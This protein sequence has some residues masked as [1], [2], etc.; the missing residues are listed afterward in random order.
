MQVSGKIMLSVCTVFL[1][2]LSTVSLF[3]IP[4]IFAA[5]EMSTSDTSSI[6]DNQVTTNGI[7]EMSVDP[8][9]GNSG[10]TFHFSYRFGNNGDYPFS[11]VIISDDNFD[12]EN[13]TP[14]TYSSG[15]TNE[16]GMVDKGETV[17]Y[18]RICSINDETIVSGHVVAQFCTDFD[19]PCT[20]KTISGDPT[21][22]RDDATICESEFAK[23]VTIS[24]V[25]QCHCTKSTISLDTGVLKGKII[26]PITVHVGQRSNTGKIPI[27]ITAKYFVTIQ[28]LGGD[29]PSCMEHW[30]LDKE[31]NSWY[32]DFDVSNGVETGVVGNPISRGFTNGED[33][34]MILECTGNDCSKTFEKHFTTTYVVE[35]PANSANIKGEVYLKVTPESLCDESNGIVSKIV[36][37][38]AI[39][40]L[41]YN[42]TQSDLDGDGLNGNQER[43]IASSD[44]SYNQNDIMAQTGL[45]DD[46]DSD[47][48]K[49]S[50]D[51]EP[52]GF[53]S[54]AIILHKSP[55]TIGSQ[56]EKSN[57]GLTTNST[58]TKLA[59][60]DQE[61][62]LEYFE[63]AVLPTYTTP[64]NQNNVTEINP[65]D[66]TSD[67]TY[68]DDLVDYE[69]AVTLPSDNPNQINADSTLTSDIS[70]AGSTLLPVND[71]F[72]NLAAFSG[73]GVST[74][75]PPTLGV[76]QNHKRI[77]DDGFSFN[78][79]AINVE[80]Y[81]TAY[82]LVTTP[83]GQNNTIK[84]KIYEEKGTDNIAHAGVSYGLG[85]GETFS[86]GQ[87]T[88]EYDK[89]FDGIE[90]VTTFD[91]KHV[92]GAVNVTTSQVK[93]SNASQSKCLEVTFHHT[94]RAPLEYN[95]VAT[96][97]WDFERDAWQNYFNH[98]IVIVGD[99][100]NPPEEYWGIYHGQI[101]HLTE[102]G[103]NIAKD[104][105]GNSWSFDRI[106]SRD[107]IK[108]VNVGMD[109]LNPEKLEALKK[110]GFQYSDG[111]KIFGYER[112][113][114]HF[115]QVVDQQQKIAQ[116][117]MK[118]LCP[119]CEVEHFEEIG[120]IFF[121]D[122]P[123]RIDKTKDPKII[124]QMNLEDQ[125]ARELLKEFFK[126]IYPD[127]FYK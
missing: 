108:P 4:N 63:R 22:I 77:V 69:S 114:P 124:N 50:D 116:D 5:N 105:K 82:P 46:F 7:F 43:S 18:Q 56:V 54:R 76:D 98:G 21:C 95:M 1:M 37:D 36:I 74:N 31:N 113:D 81:Y 120:D 87:A 25:K 51:S 6:S 118:N 90:S 60:G 100:I 10:D 85:K 117:T 92:L 99:S 30:N 104:D 65:S 47:G 122:I 38:S 57:D 70:T 112:I 61:T 127:I 102:T 126:K 29:L 83:V 17:L 111:M 12:S 89:T 107:Y 67:A 109:I 125:K 123:T 55:E 39:R 48:I 72:N 35:V 2:L 58:A 78:D 19:G 93:C 14:I 11:N 103:K 20:I 80:E 79:N 64:E 115:K 62:D 40:N 53:N 84:L 34:S 28:C 121:Y 52:A 91:P 110:R 33:G 27:T 96:N 13:C 106:W 3:E 68:T 23:S 49:N 73:G 42:P 66:D 8:H 71:F 97:I 24:F 94:F 26:K 86:K 59:Q 9:Q 32:V 101:Y 45:T 119:K 75:S 88:I 41:S 15:D 44:L 16:N